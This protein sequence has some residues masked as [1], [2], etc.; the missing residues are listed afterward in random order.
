LYD[1][2]KE[3][4]KFAVNNKGCCAL[5]HDPG[6]GKTL[7]GLEIYNHYKTINPELRLLVVCPLSLVNAAWG[8]DIKKFT[9][10][11]YSPF[12]E[13]KKAKTLPNIVVINYEA[14]ISKKNL[15]VIETLIRTYPFMCILDESSRLKNNKSVTTKTLL[16][17]SEYFQHRIIA[18]GTPMPNSEVEL[19]GQMNFVQP[20]LLHKS[21]YAFRN[22]YFHLERNGIMRRGSTYMSKDE[23]R[24]IFS[25]GWKYAITDENREFLMNEIKPFTH[26]V[27]KE[28]ALDLPEKIDET[29]D[30][31][32]SAQERQAYKEMENTLITE[33]DGVEVGVQIALSKLM[34]LRQVTAGFIYSE[35]G[36]PLPIGK[37]SKVKELENVLEELGKQQVIVWV[38][39]HHEVREI[40]KLIREKF[41]KVVT[42]YSGT[43]DRE[44]SI[45]QF[46]E[47][48]AQ[49]LIAH[50]RSA[51]HGLTFINCS[52]MV[53]FSLDYSYEA[54]AQARDRIHRIGQKSSCLYIYLVATNSIDE[55]LIQ[56]LHR[57]K[58]LQD[59]VYGIVRKKTQRK[60]SRNA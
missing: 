9:G 25:E 27:K 13:L 24:E 37:S 12:K 51:A 11:T 49:Y 46:K 2:Q 36:E 34:K 55:E 52:A 39:F 14:L 8:E 21:F 1:H 58:S 50:P 19:W 6:L 59:V 38:Q 43:K 57:K 44:E 17:L 33:I 16:K 29:R 60:S 40:E 41:G 56:V 54:H 28:E 32:L 31:S 5:F 7:S 4:I 53:F 47:N 35:D 26:W 10:F 30:V 15:P 22:T 3:A 42:L 23:L 20:E 48:E 18:S 45:R